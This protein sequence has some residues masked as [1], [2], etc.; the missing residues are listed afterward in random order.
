MTSNVS[1][2][3]TFV[4]DPYVS[5][6]YTPGTDTEE[7]WNSSGQRETYWTVLKLKQSFID[8][9]AKSD[10]Y[11]PGYALLGDHI[12]GCNPNSTTILAKK[13]LP[14]FAKPCD[15]YKLVAPKYGSDM[16]MS[17]FLPISH[18][19]NYIGLGHVA[20]HQTNWS[21][22]LEDVITPTPGD[23]YV[24]NKA[25]LF[26]AGKTAPTICTRGGI[27]AY[28]VCGINCNL[29]RAFNDNSLYKPRDQMDLDLCC[30]GMPGDCGTYT[31]KSRDC[32][33]AMS[34]KCTYKDILPGGSCYEQCISDPY[35]CDLMKNQYC[36]LHPDDKLCDCI[37]ASSRTD[38]KEMIKGA[39]M[40][41][42]TSQP[43]CYYEPCQK[44]D[45]F[46]TSAMLNYQNSGK[47]SKD[48]LAI[49]QSVGVAGEENELEAEITNDPSSSPI[50]IPDNV[51]VKCDGSEC[52]K[53]A[54]DKNFISTLFDEYGTY[55][56]I[57]LALI[58]LLIVYFIFSG[59]D[60]YERIDRRALRKDV[61]KLTKTV[62]RLKKEIKFK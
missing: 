31:Q 10:K 43:I 7:I 26:D 51:G 36:A 11:V 4:S 46:Q 2:S 61:K 25:Y 28:A 39:E 18:D 16:A 8:N 3:S 20:V 59:E 37:M 1:K 56:Y 33:D 19:S 24:V 53:N 27:N 44:G 62:G 57:A 29:F 22:K 55:T 17:L 40:V 34:N 47:C 35:N 48:M 45:A 58:I 54:T 52:D 41:Y 14:Y 15:G 12:S 38:Y 32:Y 42:G 23:Y 5:V 60:D 21:N 6:K 30:S 49:N 50:N 13:G 9:L